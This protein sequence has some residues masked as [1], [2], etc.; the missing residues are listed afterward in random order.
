MKKINIFLFILVGLV[1]QSCLTEDK[2]KFSVSASDRM[3]ERLIANENV[4]LAA[5][6][7][8]L[9]KYYPQKDKIYGG[10]TLFIDFEQENK[11][12]ATSERGGAS[13]VVESLYS[14]TGDDGPVVRFDTY[15][16]LIHYFAEPKNPD[17]IGPEDSGMQGDYEFVI[18]DAT[19]E[20]VELIGKKT[21]NTIIMEPIPAEDKWADL[22]EPIIEMG[23]K[24]KQ[25]TRF[26]YKVG[27]FTARVSQSYRRLTFLSG[28]G[29]DEK[30]ELVPYR[31][32]AEGMELFVPLTMGN[33]N[34]TSFKLVE[35]GEDSYLINE[36]TGAILTPL[37]LTLSQRLRTEDWYFAYSKTE[38][39]VKSVFNIIKMKLDTEG[40]VLGQML[41][42]DYQ[43]EFCL[44]YSAK[45]PGENFTAGAYTLIDQLDGDDIITIE[46]TY[47]TLG[48]GFDYYNKLNFNYLFLILEG[49]YRLTA[50]N[51]M[52]PTEIRLEKVDDPR[53]AFTLQKAPVSFPYDE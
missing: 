47:N 8:W 48:S 25:F 37:P 52:N 30:E 53:Y 14:L 44:M 51:K 11:V 15:N 26:E 41:M 16:E 3:E 33:V 4:F 5:P 42:T 20:R 24:L 49:T 10:Y 12:K 45:L 19:P 38:G 28:E 39:M 6:N 21:G 18:I 27:D 13:K 17:G 2:D 32:T 7:G 36:E 50:D 34:I 9:M 31:V 23:N 1:M 35:D 29:D 40:V 46:P 43:G 22:M